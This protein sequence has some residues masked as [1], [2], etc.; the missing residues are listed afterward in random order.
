VKSV[1]LDET[2]EKRLQAA[3]RVAGVTPSALI[4]Q[5]IENHCDRV[6][7]DRLDLRLADVI[8]T[9]HSQGGRAGRT[10]RAFLD[11]LR[12]RRGSA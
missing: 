2:L 12:E 6:L 1:R 11:S 8:G 3:A 7:A 4:R 5:A 9:V 10:G